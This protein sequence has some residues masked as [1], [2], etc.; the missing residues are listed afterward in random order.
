M[1]LYRNRNDTFTFYKVILLI[2]STPTVKMKRSEAICL[3]AKDKELLYCIG[4]ERSNAHTHSNYENFCSHSN[5]GWDEQMKTL[6]HCDLSVIVAYLRHCPTVTVLHHGANM[7]NLLG[8]NATIVGS[9]QKT[10][11]QSRCIT[12]MSLKQFSALCRS[13]SFFPW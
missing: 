9:L 5:C 13:L 11:F 8:R 10:P 12:L 4:T 6:K 7:D 1:F 2:S 3:Q